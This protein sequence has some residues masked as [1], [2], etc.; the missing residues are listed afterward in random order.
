LELGLGE[1]Q[2]LLVGL[3]G[4]VGSLDVEFVLGILNLELG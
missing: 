4:L 1:S 3:E 2:G